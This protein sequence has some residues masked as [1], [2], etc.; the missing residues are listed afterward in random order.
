MK[1]LIK[2]EISIATKRV[3][4]AIVVLCVLSIPEVSE[5]LFTFFNK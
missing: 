2:K 5:T 3:L 4:I 1:K